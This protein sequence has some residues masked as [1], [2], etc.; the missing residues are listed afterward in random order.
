MLPESNV[1]VPF[2]VVMRTRSSVPDIATIPHELVGEL[3]VVIPTTPCS[4]QLLPAKRVRVITPTLKSAA[5]GF[6]LV[7][8]PVVLTAFAPALPAVLVYPLVV[9]LP[10]PI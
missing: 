5:E 7:I 10:E 9:K 8:N 3:I 1:S 2:T 6:T 4:A